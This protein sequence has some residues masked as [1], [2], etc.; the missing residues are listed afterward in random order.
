MAL[1]RKF[2][3]VGAMGVA[4]FALIGAGAGASFS[5]E[6]NGTSP[7]KAGTLSMTVSSPTSGAVVNGNTVNFAQVGPTQS[8]FTS[9][10]QEVVTKNS[11]DIV[12]S[13]ITFKVTDNNNGNAAFK[14]EVYVKVDSWVSP[15]KQDGVAPI[16][17]GPLTGLE[18]MGTL[19]ISGNVPAGATDPFQVT[20]YAGDNGAPLVAPSL[21]NLAMGG[22]IAPTITVGYTG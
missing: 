7:I 8:T 3:T 10:V 4:A 20:Y 21:D 6:V 2:L 9:P 16:Y 11:G 17:N 1:S 18:A 22:W 5:G 14:N 13:A 12:A 15:N 19:T